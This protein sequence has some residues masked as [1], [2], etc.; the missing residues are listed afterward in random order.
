M[1]RERAPYSRVYWSVLDDQKFDTIRGDMRLFG[2]WS[3]MLLLADMSYPAP[4]FIPPTVPRRAVEALVDAGLVSLLPDKM[5]R[6]AGLATER[7]RRSR[8]GGENAAARWTE[9]GSQQGPNGGPEG[10]LD[11]TRRDEDKTSNDGR[12][13]LEAFL[14]V[15]RRAPTPR[16]R[17]VMDRYVATFDVTGPQRAERLILSHPDDPIGALIADLDEFR[18]G[19][20][21]EAKA[22]ESKP[23]PR[24]GIA[25]PLTQELARMLAEKQAEA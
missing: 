25:D 7:E 4:T 19:R 16:Q 18:K 21:A 24:R 23:R 13:D 9:D 12:A 20:L 1:T 8:A 11:E 15:R 2:A 22:A 6:I 10:M 17:Q 3:L 14:L 5:Y